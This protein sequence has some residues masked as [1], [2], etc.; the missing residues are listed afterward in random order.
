MKPP[1]SH[2]SLKCLWR[3][4]PGMGQGAIENRISRALQVAM[5]SGG[6]CRKITCYWQKCF[7]P[8]KI[9]HL[10]PSQRNL[11]SIKGPDEKHQPGRKNWVLPS[12]N[13]ALLRPL[14]VFSLQHQGC[15]LFPSH[16][17]QVLQ[18]PDQL[19]EIWALP[20]QLWWC[21]MGYDVMGS[22]WSW[23]STLWH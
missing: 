17:T 15:C 1:P 21:L 18:I 5:G 22:T 6:R 4:V 11:M 7:V 12:V 16:T 19:G 8:V 9:S 2:S 20:P 23:P 14:A 10:D 3:P 13:V